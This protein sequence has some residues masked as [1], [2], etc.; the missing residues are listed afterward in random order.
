MASGNLHGHGETVRYPS[1]F[2]SACKKELSARMIGAER[3]SPVLQHFRCAPS[4]EF[5]AG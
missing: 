2:T 1:M 4:M 3:L 5:L